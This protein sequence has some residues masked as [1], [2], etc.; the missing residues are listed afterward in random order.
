M[1]FRA[2]PFFDLSA[3]KNQEQR[4][5]VCQTRAHA[6]HNSIRSFVSSVSIWVVKISRIVIPR[7]KAAACPRTLFHWPL[8]VWQATPGGPAHR[9]S[10][11]ST[12]R[13]LSLRQNSLARPGV[14]HRRSRLPRSSKSLRRWRRLFS[15]LSLVQR[16]SR[17]LCCFFV[18]GAHSDA[19]PSK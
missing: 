13:Y 5:V 8:F 14:Q 1:F 3:T 18:R 19:R 4:T 17:W 15:G 6:C 12:S 16:F 10:S 2:C 7:P 9:N 11:R